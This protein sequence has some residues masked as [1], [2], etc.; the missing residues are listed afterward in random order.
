MT[1]CAVSYHRAYVCSGLLDDPL[2]LVRVRPTAAACCST[3]GRCSTWPSAPCARLTRFSS[4]TPNGPLHGTRPPGA[5]YPRFVAPARPVRPAWNCARVGHKL[6]S[7]DWNLA[8]AW[9]RTIHVHE[10]HEDRIEDHQFAGARGFAGNGLAAR[11][12]A[13]RRSMLKRMFRLKP[14]SAIMA[15]QCWSS[16]SRNGGF[17]YRSG[18]P[19]QGGIAARTV[20][21]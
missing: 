4:A 6:A 19:S 5:P 11:R 21:T 14:N 15:C 2:L 3:A 12:A 9:W 18:S 1:A 7:Y 8:E 17:Q 10:V 16:G 13:G 20:A